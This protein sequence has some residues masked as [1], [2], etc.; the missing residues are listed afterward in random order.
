MVLCGVML[1]QHHPSRTLIIEDGDS[2]GGDG[3]NEVDYAFLSEVNISLL[4]LTR[5]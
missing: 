5:M 3:V 4:N 1:D 2:S